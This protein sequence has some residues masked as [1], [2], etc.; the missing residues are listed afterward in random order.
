METAVDVPGHGDAL[1][2]SRQGGN[3]NDN[4]IRKINNKLLK[5]SR[6]FILGGG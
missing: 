5:K 6:S 4:P 2:L 1:S 3:D